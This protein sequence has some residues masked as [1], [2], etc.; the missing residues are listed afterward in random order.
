MQK[1]GTFDGPPR[2]AMCD[3]GG[4]DD[5]H[6]QNFPNDMMPPATN[7]RDETTISASASASASA[8][9]PAEASVP[10]VFKPTEAMYG[11]ARRTFEHTTPAGAENSTCSRSGKSDGWPCPQCAQTFT[12]F[13]Q[14]TK[15]AA[16]V[17]DFDGKVIKA[18]VPAEAMFCCNAAEV[19]K[20]YAR[21]PRQACSHLNYL[22]ARCMCPLGTSVVSCVPC[23][24]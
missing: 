6:I 24:V 5:W 2:N 16:E 22:G 15:R 9:P 20:A 18:A 21:D 7:D 1:E 3:G 4:D 13:V 19:A 10:R 23:K 12:T 14:N 11:L 17:K 8:R